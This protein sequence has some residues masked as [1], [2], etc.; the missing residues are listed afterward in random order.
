MKPL[1]RIYDDYLGVLA[2]VISDEVPMA[3]CGKVRSIGSATGGWIASRDKRDA[4]SQWKRAILNIP[5]FRRRL[6]KAETTQAPMFIGFR[7]FLAILTESLQLFIPNARSRTSLESW[8][9]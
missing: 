5:A 8:R 3:E 2:F 6:G 9:A 7:I 1:Q 4:M